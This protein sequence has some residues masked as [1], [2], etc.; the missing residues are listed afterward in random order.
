MILYFI[1]IILWGVEKNQCSEDES[2]FFGSVRPRF[3]Q[4]LALLIFL[5]DGDQDIHCGYIKKHP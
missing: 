4:F 1:F 5:N 2:I 3:V